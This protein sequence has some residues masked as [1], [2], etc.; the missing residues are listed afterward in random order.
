MNRLCFTGI[1][2]GPIH[3]VKRKTQK[4]SAAFALPSTPVVLDRSQVSLRSHQTV[5]PL[6]AISHSPADLLQNRTFI[7]SSRLSAAEL[8]SVLKLPQDI[9]GA[10]DDQVDAAAAPFRALLRHY[11]AAAQAA[12]SRPKAMLS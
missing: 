10:H 11:L 1:V 2:K 4:L 7:A 3:L 6:R 12:W 5:T 8:P 9:M